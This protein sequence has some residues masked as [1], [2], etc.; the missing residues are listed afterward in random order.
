MLSALMTSMMNFFFFKAHVL[1]LREQ[2]RPYSL[3][4]RIPVNYSLCSEFSV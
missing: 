2:G 1:V 3:K 4:S